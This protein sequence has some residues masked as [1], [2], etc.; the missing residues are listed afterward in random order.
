MSFF[1][2]AASAYDTLLQMGR[3]FGYRKGY[4]EMP[5]IWMTDEL[6]SWFRDLA[7]VEQE[8][9]YDI[10][11]YEIEGLTPMQFGPRIRTHPALAITAASK[12]RAATYAQMSYSGRR[13]QTILFEHKDLVWLENNIKATQ[14]LLAGADASGRKAD[15]DGSRAIFKDV[16]SASVLNFLSTYEFHQNSRELDA[17]LLQRYIR[18]Q[19]EHGELTSWTIA[20]L[21]LP[22][23]RKEL[24]SIPLGVIGDVP[25]I[26]RSRVIPPPGQAYA[27]IKSLM[28]KEDRAVD[29]GLTQRDLAGLPQGEIARLRDPTPRGRGDGFRS[30]R[31]IPSARRHARRERR[32]DRISMRTNTSSASALCSRRPRRMTGVRTT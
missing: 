32:R 17:T 6:K 4:E 3:W 20:V 10:E 30:W 13:I 25:L 11:R 29:L 8:I 18:A 2:R 1:V 15:G 27:N 22:K 28:S 12:M 7:T 31:S 5:R 16:E 26:N 24:G 21:G 23:E 14:T 9:R 19:N